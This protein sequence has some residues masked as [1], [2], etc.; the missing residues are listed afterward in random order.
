MGTYGS[1]LSPGMSHN[2]FVAGISKMNVM[3]LISLHTRSRS[4]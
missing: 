1:I 4:S 3:D 2:N